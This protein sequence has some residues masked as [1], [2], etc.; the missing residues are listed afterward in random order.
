MDEPTS[1]LDKFHEDEMFRLLTEKVFKDATILTIS[2][3]VA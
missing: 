3:L 2:G 1:S